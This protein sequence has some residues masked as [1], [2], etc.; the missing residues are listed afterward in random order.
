MSSSEASQRSQGLDTLRALAIVLVFVYHYSIFVSREP[1][2]GWASTIGWTGVD[3]FF[4]L[5]G[6]LIADSLLAGLVQGRR[7]SLGAFYMR[8]GLR[9]WPLF[10]VVLAA[11]FAWPATMGGK[12]PP[13]LWTFLTF[14]QNFGLPPG[15]A[16]SHAWSLCIEEQFYLVLPLVL[17]LGARLGGRRLHGWVL[18]LAL[19]TT[20]IVARAVLWQSYGQ[21]S[22][23]RIAGYHP[24]IYYA[25]L[26]RI[27]EFL[28][29]VA[30]AMLKN[31]H[32]PTWARLMRHGQALLA[33]G[34]A[35]T[36]GVWA[37]VVQFYY[38]DGEGYGFFMTAFGYSLMALAFAPLVM[39]AQS[40]GSWL[41]RVRIPGAYQ[42]A[43]W[44]YA[45]YLSHKAIAHI[46][47]VQT[48]SWGLSPEA[49]LALVT[50]ACLLGG[51]LLHRAVEA[52]FMA[53]RGRWFPT[54]FAPSPQ[55]PGGQAGPQPI[56]SVDSP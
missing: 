44:S 32:A 40:P 19:L 52:P 38:I 4:V 37:L 21:Q 45:I 29:G 10:W 12:T 42:L 50:L 23:G 16:F 39:A 35:A 41:A 3:L 48:A 56:A 53:L 6:F 47:Q 54:N 8:R 13:P 51:V 27:D 31:L 43:V 20:G 55:R 2:F 46:V 15:T 22:G 49:L 18:L 24:H 11:Y 30:V 7:L 25:T 28:P 9:T 36:V 17:V 5:S 33:L 14:T 1:S 34:V 26:C